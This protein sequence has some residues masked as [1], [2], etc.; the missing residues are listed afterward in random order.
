MTRKPLL[1]N[2]ER[3]L[4]DIIAASRLEFFVRGFEQANINRI[5]QQASVSKRTLYRY[6]ESKNVLFHVI[7]EQELQNASRLPDYDYEPSQPLRDQLVAATYNEVQVLTQPSCLPFL[8]ILMMELLSHPTEPNLFLI[9][10]RASQSLIR[11]VSDAISDRALKPVETSVVLNFYQA[12]FNGMFVW[13]NL[14]QQSVAPL[15]A[16]L[17]AKVDAVVDVFLCQYAT[18]KN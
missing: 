14:I 15:Q 13:P 1:K 11:W 8:R 17:T 10:T 5:C 2:S 4:S 18:T 12:L 16:D 3:I 7:L 9:K 6:F